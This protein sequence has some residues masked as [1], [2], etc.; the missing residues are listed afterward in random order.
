M[1]KNVRKNLL[2]LVPFAVVFLTFVTMFGVVQQSL[3]G[4]ADDPQIQMAEDA[5]AQ[6]DSGTPPTRLAMGSVDMS[7]SLA[8]YLII[9]DENGAVVAGSGKLDGSVPQVPIGVLTNAQGKDYHRVTWQPEP[10]VRQAAV[11]VAA[12]KYYVLSG[13]SLKE[14]EK[15]TQTVF[16]LTILGLGLSWAAVVGGWLLWMQPKAR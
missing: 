8:P 2:F 12:H 14:I 11:S 7:R 5:A 6:L 1:R 3:R 13:R 4:G 15:R 9:Y 16:W 10:G